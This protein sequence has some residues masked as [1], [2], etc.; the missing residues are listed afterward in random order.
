MSLLRI[1]LALASLCSVWTHHF[2]IFSEL[3]DERYFLDESKP[4]PVVCDDG[5]CT[6]FFHAVHFGAPKH[7]I[8]KR[9]AIQI[10]NMRDYIKFL[11]RGNKTRDDDRN[12]DPYRTGNITLGTSFVLKF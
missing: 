12:N 2:E 7:K 9:A 6:S 5:D 10:D 8:R 4:V 3:H 11:L 1:L